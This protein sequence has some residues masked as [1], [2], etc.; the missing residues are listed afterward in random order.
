MGH[1]K[2]LQETV[3]DGKGIW[4]KSSSVAKQGNK[5]LD[6]FTFYFPFLVQKKFY[7]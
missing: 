7:K 2:N 3:C 1:K 5:I 4:K 6:T